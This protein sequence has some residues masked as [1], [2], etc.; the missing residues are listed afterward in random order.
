MCC[1]YKVTTSTFRLL[2]WCLHCQQYACYTQQLLSILLMLECLVFMYTCSKVNL[3][4]VF[5]YIHLYMCRDLSPETHPRAIQLWMLQLQA[6]SHLHVVCIVADARMVL[7]SNSAW[8]ISVHVPVTVAHLTDLSPTCCTVITQWVLCNN[9]W[10]IQ[11]GFTKQ[12]L[13]L[14]LGPGE[15]PMTENYV[16]PQFIPSVLADLGLY[17]NSVT[18]VAL[19][20]R[21]QTLMPV[22]FAGVTALKVL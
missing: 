14:Q 5:W 6:L 17:Q 12:G 19:P 1:M 3:H 2:C 10:I 11:R 9:G 15:S 13:S 22:Y 4:R 7:Y 8:S 21:N 18:S 16:P 20:S